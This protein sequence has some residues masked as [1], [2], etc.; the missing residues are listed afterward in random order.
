TH[1]T[2]YLDISLIGTPNPWYLLNDIPV[3]VSAANAVFD[4]NNTVYLI[5]LNMIYA[6][7]ISNNQWYPTGSNGVDGST[8]N[9][10]N[11]VQ[12]PVYDT[13]SG[14][15]SAVNAVGDIIQGRE[16]FTAVLAPDGNIIIYGGNNIKYSPIPTM[17]TLNTNTSPY[18]WTAKQIG[19]DAPQYITG[20][21]AAINGTHMIIALGATSSNG[22]FDFTTSNAII[23]HL[24]YNI[25]ALSIQ[26][27]VWS[28]NSTTHTQ[29]ATQTP[30]PFSPS[31]SNIGAIMIENVA[32]VA[33]L[34][35]ILIIEN[36]EVITDSEKHPPSKEGATQD[37]K[38]E[39][40]TG[41]IESLKATVPTVYA[42]DIE[43]E[44]EGAKQVYGAVNTVADV[45]DPVGGAAVRTGQYVAGSA[46]EGIGKMSGNQ[47]LKDV[48]EV[49]KDGSL[50]PYRG[51]IKSM[52]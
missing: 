13:I 7:N 51:F 49:V 44:K 41:I 20:H 14:N 3:S 6:Y 48:S 5:N 10:I 39:P 9:Y 34:T 50:E 1:Q 46:G 11:M 19:Q 52:K 18:T 45:T 24:N 15:W 26:N 40:T 12:I 42:S 28:L 33:Y 21:V 4:D 2:M 29:T 35:I 27:S 32:T 36:V 47:D 25:Y 31:S 22:T 37:E 17:A 38:Q 8:R 43:R 30:T 16:L 23:N